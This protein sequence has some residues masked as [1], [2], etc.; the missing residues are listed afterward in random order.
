MQCSTCNSCTRHTFSPHRQHHAFEHISQH[1]FKSDG[2]HTLVLGI[3]AGW[4][5]AL[6][7]WMLPAAGELDAF[8]ILVVTYVV[9][10]ASFPHVIA[11]AVDVFYGGLHGV[12]PWR[13]VLLGFV[14]PTLIG[15]SIGGVALVAGLAHAQVA[16]GGDAG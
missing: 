16:S 10:L 13:Q 8:V 14:I 15:N 12:A 7:V 3:F 2:L 5:I 11:G 6:M 9:G 4:L 1:A